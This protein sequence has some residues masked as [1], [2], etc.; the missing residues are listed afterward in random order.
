MKAQ[1]VSG[2]PGVGKSYSAGKHQEWF[3]ISDSDSSNFSWLPDG[4]RHPDFPQNYIEHMKGV[5]DDYDI[6]FVSSHKAVRDSL[7]ENKL[8]FTVIY[9]HRSLKAEYL[10]R[11]RKRG[12]PEAFVSMMDQNWDKF[13]D[14]LIELSRLPA[15]YG[16]DVI[17][18]FGIDRYL[19]I[20]R[21]ILR[22]NTL[23][24]EKV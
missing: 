13:Q 20:K 24:G 6:I 19:D 2:F 21:D 15:S 23:H 4:T 18:L 17:E 1:I 11:Y 14:E 22:F 16:V 9:P 8:P 5:G 7:L 10:E 12:S 3:K